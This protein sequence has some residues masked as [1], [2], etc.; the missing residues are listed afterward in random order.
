[1]GAS[2][3]HGNSANGTNNSS[4]SSSSQKPC[5]ETFVTSTSKVLAPSGKEF[6]FVFAHQI[7]SHVDL[8]F[9]QAI[10]VRQLDS[11]L[12]PESCFAVSVR[13]HAFPPAAGDLS[14][15]PPRAR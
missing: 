10:I 4:D 15:G 12:K 9:T 6:P 5:F 7:F 8:A 11:R 2:L 1:M 14:P 13:S 3:N